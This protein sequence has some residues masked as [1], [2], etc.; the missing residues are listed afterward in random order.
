MFGQLGVVV[1]R[2]AAEELGQGLL[3][4]F[5]QSLNAEAVR[6]LV[7]VWA[8]LCWDNPLDEI[9]RHLNSVQFGGLRAEVTH[10]CWGHSA[11]DEWYEKFALIR[12]VS[13]PW[14]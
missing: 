5:P 2:P 8:S 1:C 12:V 6:S 7:A 10:S 3:H 11:A 4:A 14:G 13:A 9:H